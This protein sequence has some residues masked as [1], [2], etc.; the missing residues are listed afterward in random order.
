MQK[1]KK[2]IKPAMDLAHKGHPGIEMDNKGKPI[3]IKK[4]L[5]EDRAKVKAA[6]AK[7]KK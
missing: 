1:K 5:P 2:H 7:K 6:S 4:R 3:P